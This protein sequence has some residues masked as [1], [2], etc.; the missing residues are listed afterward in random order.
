MPQRVGITVPLARVWLAAFAVGAYSGLSL[1]KS[2]PPFV[3]I[4]EIPAGLDAALSFAM[5]LLIAFR[6]NRAY[7]RWW[8]ARTLWGTLVNASRNLAVKIRELQ[9]PDLEE[10]RSLRDL[11][12]AY[13]MGLRDH[14]RDEADITKLPRLDHHQA[15]PGHI[16][17]HV[18]RALYAKIKS[19]QEQGK[20]SDE[21]LWVLDSEVRVFLQVCGACERIKTTLMPIS[22]R[23]VTWQ[24][25]AA[26]LALFP[27][28][29]V[30]DFGVWTIPLTILAA[31]VVMAGEAVAH[32]VEEPFGD[33]EDHLGLQRVCDVIDRSVTEILVDA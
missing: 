9:S 25:I 7:E 26:Y 29:L 21:Q 3:Y 1:L 17:S 8:E 32:H 12:V 14:L 19:W 20:L 10:R 11:I 18:V 24:C 5:A 31:Y 13:C 6:V 23:L 22:W 16:P 2:Y 15:A 4:P 33:H 28:G 27:W 30:D